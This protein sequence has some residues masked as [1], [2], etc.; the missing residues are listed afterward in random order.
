MTNAASLLQYTA[1]QGLNVYGFELSNE[2][3]TP[4]IAEQDGKNVYIDPT[5]GD[6]KCRHRPAFA[7][8]CGARAWDALARHGATQPLFH[9]SVC[10]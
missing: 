6:A 1:E 9:A 5:V 4:S 3:N 10:D 7:L 8:P 2:D